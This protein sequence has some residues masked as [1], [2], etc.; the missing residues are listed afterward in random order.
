MK[1]IDSHCHIDS[2][3]K[4]CKITTFNNLKLQ[5]YSEQFEACITVSCDPWS[6]EN[7][8]RQLENPEIY[9]AFGIHPHEAKYYDDNL[10][11]KI[12]DTMN[13]VKTL[14]WGEIGLDFHYNLTEQDIQKD[15]FKRQIL[16][17][18]KV[19]KPI[20]IHSRKAE[21]DTLDIVNHYIPEN[22]KVHLHCYTS[23][24][25]MALQLLEKFPNLYIGFTGAI[26]FN[27]TAE[28][29]ETVNKIPLDRLLLETDGP[30]MAP[31]PYRGKPCHSGYIPLIA[32]KI[33]EIKAIP[34]DQV[35][36]QIRV[37]TR[38]MYGI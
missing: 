21:T 4:K 10:E 7:T 23:S 22:W 33:S 27:N 17:A 32:E 1:Y 9:G 8:L 11:K 35:Y 18:I 19:N 34:L 28:I 37:N 14:A 5:H 31:V 2:I 36:D 6:I 30:Y 29:Q 16:A 26:T 13:H 3:L 15:V 38:A 12:I 24:T 20:I 25:E